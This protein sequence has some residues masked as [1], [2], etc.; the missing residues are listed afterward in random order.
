MKLQDAV[1]GAPV[2]QVVVL[3]IAGSVGDFYKAV[4]RSGLHWLLEVDSDAVAADRDFS[5]AADAAA[6]V[7]TKLFLILS[8]Q[9]AIQQIVNLWD[10]YQSDG[11]GAFK[12]GF[13]PWLHV[14]EQLRAVRLWDIRDRV[15]PDTSSYWQQRIE[16]GDAVI[17][18]EIELWYS[19]SEHT[20]VAWANGLR[21]LLQQNG[22]AVID[23][24]GISGIRYHAFLV[25]LPAAAVQLILADENSP[26]AVAGQ[27]M[28]YRP[29][30]R[31][32][33]PLGGAET[34]PLAQARPV[35]TAE[36]VVAIMDGVPLQNH[37]LLGARIILD[38]P[39]GLQARA[40]PG[41]RVHGT[42]M[43][44]IVLHGDLNAG[45]PT[46]ASR[47]VAH[48]ILIPDPLSRDSPREE[49]SVPDRLLLDVIHV[50]V[51]RLVE[52]AGGQPPVA[53]SVRV[54]N[55]S[56]GD[57][58]REF[59]RAM[60]PL[61]RLLDWLAWKYQVLFVVPTGNLPSLATGL[62]LNVPREEFQA[63]SQE[64]RAQAALDAIELDTH[65]RRLLSP[66]ESLNALTVGGVYADASTF[67]A[68]P[69]RFELFP[70]AWACPEGRYGPGFLRAIKPDLVAPSGRR[71]F[72]E[73]QGNV[74][75][76]ATLIPLSV[77]NPPGIL[78]A[79]PAA[80]GNLAHVKCSAGT[81]NAAALVSHACAHAH[82]AIA[83]IRQD[84]DTH[85]FLPTR[86]DAVL[87]KAL[88][89]HTCQWPDSEV[90]LQALEPADANDRKRRMARLFGY[91]L[92]DIDRARGCTDERA[93]LIATGEIAA[94]EGQEYFIPLPPSLAG[95]RDW[96]RLTITLAW[97]SPINPQ[98][99]DYRRA[100]LWFTCNRAPLK[101][102]AAGADWQAMRRGTVQHDVWEGEKA[103]AYTQDANL[104][105][106]V[107]CAPDAGELIDK[108]QYALCV[109][110]EVAPGIELPIY[111]EVAARIG[112]RVPIAA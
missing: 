90:L 106:L 72:I 67:P 17:R 62:E 80:A 71:L 18:T 107:S 27:V 26:L 20:N 14:F 40:P 47:I 104:S 103:A 48:P 68:M 61:A 1:E 29:H 54:I 36:P 9:T 76:Q 88:T 85:A 91:G 77:G 34:S 65:F 73:K 13:T 22:S 58:R 105:L 102:A 57:L 92:V 79:S 16:A 39:D 69:G 81:S 21:A 46:I 75:A 38:D 98:H 109:S 108:I 111:E 66:A 5:I 4:N 19:D 8:D 3:E 63:L 25:D 96:R 42:S 23:A 84:E 70:E 30:L 95:K 97:L 28:Y 89:V 10:R 99:H 94:E 24:A 43:A 49:I 12:R 64:E 6:P 101:I 33:A 53:P 100:M 31:A 11:A 55:L 35:P 44:S 15:E 41:D 56:I 87:L 83:K 59:V 37:Q 74:H 60:S 2:E 7:P 78:S 52:G 112:V 32:M 45:T 51:K 110:I 86:L 93:T 82:D 50:G